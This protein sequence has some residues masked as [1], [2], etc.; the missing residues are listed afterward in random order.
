MTDSDKVKEL[1]DR[2]NLILSLS[3][4]LRT[5]KR[6]YEGEVGILTE[7][8]KELEDEQ[9]QRSFI[10]TTFSGMVQNA[11]LEF[12]GRNGMIDSDYV[13]GILGNYFKVAVIANDMAVS[14]LEMINKGRK[15]S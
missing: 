12:M 8:V 1:D 2:D 5:N 7:R 9:K 4:Q 15:L 11:A 6:H 10:E 13:K 14:R 3:E